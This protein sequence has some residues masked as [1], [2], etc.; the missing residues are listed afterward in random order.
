M[1]VVAKQ[2]RGKDFTEAKNTHAKIEALFG[3]SLSM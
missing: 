1:C 2:R 3:A